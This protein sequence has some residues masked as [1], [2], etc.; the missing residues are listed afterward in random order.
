MSKHRIMES[1]VAS[2]TTVE[3]LMAITGATKAKLEE[4]AKRDVAY[5]SRC[6]EAELMAFGL[7][8]NQTAKLLA[9]FELNRRVGYTLPEQ[10]QSPKDVANYFM[11]R[12][13]HLD[14][15]CFWVMH[16]SVKNRIIS[17]TK[18]YTGS[19]STAM[20]RVSEVYK[21]AIRV[22]AAAI[23][24][25]HNHPSGDPSPSAD[26]VQVTRDVFAAGKLLDIDLLDHLIIGHNDYTSLRERG[27]G[28]N[29]NK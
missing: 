26:D 2:E 16:L 12:Y 24:I 10:I 21:E 25:A 9:A 6:S 17:V 11:L 27:L 3:L 20:I 4:L 14:Q 13:S 18:L 15:E 1:G 7:T 22:N 29:D 23:I 28:F 19:V 8:E 5:I